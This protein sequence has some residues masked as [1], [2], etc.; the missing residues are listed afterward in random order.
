MARGEIECSRLAKCDVLNLKVIDGVAE[1]GQLILAAVFASSFAQLGEEV[2]VA[3]LLPLQCVDT[4]V[5][6]S[7]HLAHMKGPRPVSLQCNTGSR[8]VQAL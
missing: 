6:G 3:E 4:C 7:N 2:V 5:L 1:V 8:T